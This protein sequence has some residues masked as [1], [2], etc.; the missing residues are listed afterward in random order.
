MRKRKKTATP[1]CTTP[2][3]STH[4][5]CRGGTGQSGRQTPST[6]NPEPSHD[7]HSPT[8]L[9][10]PTLGY[11]C[12]RGT[13]V[14]SLRSGGDASDPLQE[15]EHQRPGA[16]GLAPSDREGRGVVEGEPPR[17]PNAPHKEGA[18]GSL[19]AATSAPAPRQDHSEA[20]GTPRCPVKDLALP[21]P[22]RAHKP[23]AALSR[24]LYPPGTPSL[25]HSPLTGSHPFQNSFPKHAA[26]APTPP[27]LPSPPP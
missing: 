17:E 16:H 6:S 26:H 4:T 5:S 9:P 21:G 19:A 14:S 1:R 22:Q 13:F 7:T 10:D 24:P 20:P 2:E 25:T 12:T 3:K 11:V 18:L 15:R 8:Q 27:A 23:R